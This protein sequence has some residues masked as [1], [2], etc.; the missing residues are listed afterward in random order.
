MYF[1]NGVQFDFWQ[2]IQLLL[3]TIRQYCIIHKGAVQRPL[4]NIVANI[5]VTGM[6][7]YTIIH[8]SS[9]C[10]YR[11]TCGSRNCALVEC[12]IASPS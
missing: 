8:Q 9:F 12:S 7:L 10:E 11:N 5:K 3:I 6:S 2:V 4:F 1:K